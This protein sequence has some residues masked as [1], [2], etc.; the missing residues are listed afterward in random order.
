[1]L[2]GQPRCRSGSARAASH[3]RTLAVSDMAL[4]N[5]PPLERRPATIGLVVS[6]CRH[7]ARGD[8]RRTTDGQR[9]TRQAS[10]SGMGQRDGLLDIVAESF[11]NPVYGREQ[12]VTIGPV[13]LFG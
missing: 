1:M 13:H 9:A 11:L 8:K 12:R 3:A 7:R 2:S 6:V 10:S 4:D 5:T